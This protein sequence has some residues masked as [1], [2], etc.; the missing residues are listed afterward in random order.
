MLKLTETNG[1]NTMTIFNRY[2]EFFES[3]KK[4]YPNGGLDFSTMSNSDIDGFVISYMTDLGGCSARA[5]Y[6][7]MM[8]PSEDALEEAYSACRL[9]LDRL[10][11]KY[12]DYCDLKRDGKFQYLTE[13][14]LAT[15]YTPTDQA[16]YDAG[17]K[18]SDF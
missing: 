12:N 7:L 14:N 15:K 13:E 16:M 17:H 18:H 6:Q 10:A 8:K 4:A 5:A 9:E 11:M 2:P 1:R 3:C